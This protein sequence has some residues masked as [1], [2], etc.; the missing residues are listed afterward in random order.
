MPFS[1]DHKW[2]L[3]PPSPLHTPIGCKWV[4]QIK[5]HPDGRIE[6]NKARLVA[7]GFHQQPGIDY[8][9]TFSPVVKPATIR[10]ILSLAISRGWS[11]RQLDIKNAFLHAF[12]NEDVYMIQPPG[13]D[14]KD[15]GPLNYFLGL[16]VTHSNGSLHLS[17]VKYAH[18]LLQ[19]WAGCPD[20]RPSTTGY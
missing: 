5:R 2:S 8:T 7:K 20:S 6:R 15:L 9:E 14:I 13:F 1:K 19:H 12:L 16:Q 17:Q 11:L 4:F 3:V 18:D 10:I